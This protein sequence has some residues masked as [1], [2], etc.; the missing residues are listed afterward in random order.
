LKIQ[1]LIFLELTKEPVNF[2]LLRRRTL[3]SY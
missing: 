3:K 1:E 2:S